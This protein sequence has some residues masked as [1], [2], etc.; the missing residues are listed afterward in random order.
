MIRELSADE[1]LAVSGGKQVCAYEVANR[2]Y[3][4]REQTFW[5]QVI[6]VVNSY[7]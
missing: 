2:C 7:K 3:A 1:L 6:D 4:W 5:E